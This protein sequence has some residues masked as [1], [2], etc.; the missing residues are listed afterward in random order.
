[1][2]YFNKSSKLCKIT[3]VDA[4]G[5]TYTSGTS[6]EEKATLADAVL[7]FNKAGNF[8]VPSKI[9]FNTEEGKSA[10]QQFLAAEKKEETIKDCIYTIVNS[11][12][13]AEITKE[14]NKFVYLN[15]PDQPRI[16]KRQVAVIVYK[17]GLHSVYQTLPVAKIAL[18]LWDNNH[19]T[20]SIDSIKIK[21][22]E[23]SEITGPIASDNKN[24]HTVTKESTQTTAEKSPATDTVK[25]PLE[26]KKNVLTF[27]E[28][29]G[30]VSQKEF[31]ERAVK[32]TKDLNSYLKIL[33]TK[34]YGYEEHNK[35]L[36]QAIKLFI[37]EDA[38]VQVSSI[39]KDEIKSY[40]IRQ[41]LLR[42]KSLNYDR[43]EV[44]WTNVQYVD[45]L[46]KGPDGNYYGTVT[47][48]QVFRGFIDGKVVYEDVT[49]KSATVVL[50]AY[51]KNMEGNT[52]EM[53]D[54]MLSDIG[55][56]YTKSQAQPL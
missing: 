39:T 19:A 5:I 44:E 49:K 55:V 8:L 35:A 20:S 46:K 24:I 34:T 32:K 36:D 30:N 15:L 3:A 25:T 28:L 6:K 40:K 42:L 38:A 43:V 50:K 37:N 27:E 41:Y 52:T 21:S 51:E 56:I 14:D 47:L 4:D 48:E 12:I 23:T 26:E 7:L 54:V 13:E 22:T 9:D 1:M 29:T 18:I 2:I 11:K 17:N 53:W 45:K 31:E 33:C 10:T 16:D